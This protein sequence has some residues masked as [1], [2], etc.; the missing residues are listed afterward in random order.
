MVFKKHGYCIGLVFMARVAPQ[1]L[2]IFEFFR[3]ISC[4]SVGLFSL[5]F[6]SSKYAGFITIDVQQ[7]SYQKK[8][9]ASKSFVVQLENLNMKCFV[10]FLFEKKRNF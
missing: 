2:I 6:F 5:C 7:G 3:S 4:Y 8:N 9:Y 10:K 1:Y